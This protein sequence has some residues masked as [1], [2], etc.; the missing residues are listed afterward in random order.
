MPL[1]F[2]STT[3]SASCSR[4]RTPP[5]DGEPTR[6]DSQGMGS[7]DGTISVPHANG[8]AVNAGCGEL[9]PPFECLCL[10]PPVSVALIQS[11]ARGDSRHRSSPLLH[12]LVFCFASPVVGVLGRHRERGLAAFFGKSRRP[13]RPRGSIRQLA[14]FQVEL[15]LSC[16]ATH[17]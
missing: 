12:A 5:K 15:T 4:S 7:N 17:G 2:S 11:H 3:R 14:V 13:G 9:G 1:S 6:R 10:L 16:G 8:T